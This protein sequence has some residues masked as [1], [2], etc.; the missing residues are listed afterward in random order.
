MADCTCSRLAFRPSR[1][2]CG[3]S[4]SQRSAGSAASLP[5]LTNPS[6]TVGWLLLRTDGQHTCLPLV[7]APVLHVWALS[8]VRMAAPPLKLSFSV[9]YTFDAQKRR[10]SQ[11]AVPIKD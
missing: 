11:G 9:A 5:A 10:R 6:Y 2:R 3:G 4:A 8:P 7:V 1:C